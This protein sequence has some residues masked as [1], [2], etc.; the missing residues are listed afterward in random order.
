MNAHT[1][2]P[3]KVIIA[4]DFAKGMFQIVTDE[5]CPATIAFVCDDIPAGKANAELF[6]LAPQL[7]SQRNE[8]REALDV[9]TRY[10]SSCIDHG[11]WADVNW[12]AI[13]KQ[14]RT[15]LANAKD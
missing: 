12:H 1:P 11:R 6:A 5:A 4:E 2:G 9:A 13:E 15:A 10:I 3:L 7:L 8:L 14:A